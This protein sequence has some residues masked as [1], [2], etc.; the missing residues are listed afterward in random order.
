MWM[1]WKPWARLRAVVA[2]AKGE[3]VRGSSTW[4]VG[5]VHAFDAEALA[6]HAEAWH[7]AMPAF[8]VWGVDAAKWQDRGMLHVDALGAMLSA[9]KAG[10]NALV[11]AG[12]SLED[13][14]KHATL[15]LAFST[16]VLS[17][18]AMARAARAVVSVAL[19][20]GHGGRRRGA[21]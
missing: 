4:D 9:S 2:W 21:A 18:V 3:V 17:S 20:D 10:M 5:R 1:A 8:H 7:A 11:A 14:A 16:D 12:W 15:R 13:A 6:L 19:H